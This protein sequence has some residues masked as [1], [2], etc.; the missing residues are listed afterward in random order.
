MLAELARP[1]AA[2]VHAVA[3]TEELRR[4]RHAV[5][6]ALEAERRRV[7]RDLHDGLGPSLAAV[8]MQLD[9]ARALVRP[10]PASAEATMTRLGDDIRSTIA[11]V[12][13][14]VY[15]LHPPVLDDV[16]LIPALAERTA[17]FSGP[18]PDGRR[19]AVEL[20]TPDDPPVLSP[21]IELAA[22]RI[23]CEALNN[24]VRHA[25][26]ERCRVTLLHRGGTDLEV[27]IDDDGSG[28]S[29]RAR[30]GVG[31]TSMTQRVA[32]V[33]GS[34]QLGPSPLGGTR[35]W[36]RVPLS[37]STGVEPTDCTERTA[38]SDNGSAP[39]EVAP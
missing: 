20:V 3:T 36:A 37:P 6:E 26:A 18:T 19:L 1:S 33:G 10:D 38:S 7:R 39:F 11:D 35:V 22:Y 34:C 28:V 2:V 8:A 29:E 15:D 16:G 12:R 23:V 4:S 13:L 5:V 17:A 32:E 27:L 9:G 21:G 30:A 31:T 25:R 14:L 24:V